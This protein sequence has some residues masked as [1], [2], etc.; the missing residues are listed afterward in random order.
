MACRRLRYSLAP[1]EGR[2]RMARCWT[3]LVGCAGLLAACGGPDA[4]AHGGYKTPK[5]RPWRNPT[6]I[7]LDDSLEAEVDD[8]VSYPKR[9]RA[10]WFAVDVPSFGSLE[11]QVTVAELSDDRDL[12][13]AFEVMD[14]GFRVIAKADREEDDTGEEQKVRNLKQLPPGRVYVHVYAQRRLDEADFTLQLKFRPQAGTEPTNFPASV[15]FI[16]ALPDVPLRD[17]APEPAPVVKKCKGSRCKKR[18]PKVEE[19][20]PPP[21]SIRARIAGIVESGKGVQ[22]R[23]NQGASQGIEVGW[24]GTVVSRDG[25]PIMGGQFEISRVSPGESFAIVRATK[26]SVTSAKYVRL[27]PP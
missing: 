9:Q 13:L 27:R 1:M 10:R 26:D 23:I 21:R 5:V 19:A 11:V 12:D 6:V 15:A 22:I 24:K 17:D 2:A 7:L 8:T 18:V 16:G 20:Q 14:E 4:P 25:K 3:A